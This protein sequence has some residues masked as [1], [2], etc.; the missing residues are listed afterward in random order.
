MAV[1][2]D[3]LFNTLD[4]HVKDGRIQSQV[5]AI[6]ELMAQLEDLRK[7]KDAVEQ[8]LKRTLEEDSKR[9]SDGAGGAFVRRGSG[10]VDVVVRRSKSGKRIRC[11]SSSTLVDFDKRFGRGKLLES[12]EK[13]LFDTKMQLCVKVPSLYAAKCTDLRVLFLWTHTCMHVWV[14]CSEKGSTCNISYLISEEVHVN[15]QYHTIMELQWPEFFII[16]L[17]CCFMEY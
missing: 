8:K 12:T 15:V 16:S 3:L 13:E 4:N 9:Y 10:V 2:V 7:E 11:Q 1:Q 5:E 6:A 17:V 14:R